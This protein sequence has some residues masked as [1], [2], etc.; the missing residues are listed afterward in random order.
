M[1]ELASAGERTAGL[2]AAVIGAAVSRGASLT[3][4][5]QLHGDELARRAAELIDPTPPSVQNPTLAEAIRRA[6]ELASTGLGRARLRREPPR[7]ERTEAEP[8]PSADQATADAPGD[9]P[10]DEEP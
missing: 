2:T 4:L 5:N 6:D 3:I 1:A 7:P 8:A 9:V 10:R